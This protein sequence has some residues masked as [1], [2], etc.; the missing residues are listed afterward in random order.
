MLDLAVSD[1]VLVTFFAAMF[2]HVGVGVPLPLGFLAC[3]GG[4]VEKYVLYGGRKNKF[5]A[6]RFK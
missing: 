3:D 5:V 4:I 1:S 6:A 2:A